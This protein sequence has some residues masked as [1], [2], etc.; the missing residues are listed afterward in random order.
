VFLNLVCEFGEK[1][2]DDLI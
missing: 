1:G 2:R